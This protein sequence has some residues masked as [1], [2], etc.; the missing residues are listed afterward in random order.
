MKYYKKKYL[1][2]IYDEEDNFINIVDDAKEFAEYMKIDKN[3]ADA[4]LSRL[5][6]TSDNTF[7]RGKKK[8]YIYF[9]DMTEE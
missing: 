9:I 5:S 1:I 7:G 8:V 6:S 3:V 4:V 2:A